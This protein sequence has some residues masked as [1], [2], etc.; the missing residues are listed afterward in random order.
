MS[1]PVLNSLL[2]LNM[3]RREICESIDSSSVDQKEQLKL[4][5]MNE[6]SDYEVLHIM[7]VGEF[8]NEK[9][10][11]V[12]ED[13]LWEFIRKGF[14][15]NFNTLSETIEPQYLDELIFEIG[16]IYPYGMSSS[17]PLIEHQ[18]IHGMMTE[19]Y[20]NEKAFGFMDRVKDTFT[21]HKQPAQRAKAAQSHEDRKLAGKTGE[22]TKGEKVK[23]FLTK[24][25]GK[26]GAAGIAAG[27]AGLYGAY[28]LYKK[29]K[30]EKEAAAKKKTAAATA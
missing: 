9:F 18:Y 8:P 20:L 30:A 1:H 4:L 28:K 25:K 10:N 11:P 23:R 7:T 27:A 19:E 2:F 29:K 17:D 26:L 24:N 21:K 15:K 22:V 16:P 6:A 14:A 5:V 13:F 12:I 3:A